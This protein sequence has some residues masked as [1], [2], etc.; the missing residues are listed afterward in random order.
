MKFYRGKRNVERNFREI[1]I[2][3]DGGKVRRVEQR[4]FWSSSERWEGNTVTEFKFQI[5]S[6]NVYLFQ[7]MTKESVL[8]HTLSLICVLVWLLID[9][10]ETGYSQLRYS[11][12][13]F[14]CAINFAS[15]CLWTTILFLSIALALAL[16]KII[17]FF[18]NDTRFNPFLRTNRTASQMWY[19][20]IE[21]F[22]VLL[23]GIF[24]LSIFLSINYKQGLLADYRRKAL[25][26][27][28]TNGQIRHSHH[29][30]V[31]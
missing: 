22:S 2:S 29:V 19:L 9:V 10:E 7:S 18:Y 31:L 8:S 28:A 11:S 21:T 14:Y 23:H 13:F 20:W 26:P 17:Y 15:Y 12:T 5:V 24:V 25:S 3:E 27:S 4:K 1:S 30:C 6:V 16:K